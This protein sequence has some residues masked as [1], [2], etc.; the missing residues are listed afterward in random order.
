M[1]TKS[2]LVICNGDDCSIVVG[3]FPSP[4]EAYAAADSLTRHIERNERSHHVR[5][6]YAAMFTPAKRYDALWAATP[7]TH[8]SEGE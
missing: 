7:R 8:R 6:E 2:A 5:I 1:K 3:P 4:D